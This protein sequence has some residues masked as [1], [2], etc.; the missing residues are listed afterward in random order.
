MSPFGET[1]PSGV[2]Q[3]DRLDWMDQASRQKSARWPNLAPLE[4]LGRSICSLKN[5]P[6]TA[7]LQ[8]LIRRALPVSP[9][10]GRRGR[11]PWIPR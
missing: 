3:D 7:E 1:E 4:T 8:G 5:E 10:D 9:S 6:N 11:C 2:A